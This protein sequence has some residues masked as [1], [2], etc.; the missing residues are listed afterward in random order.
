MEPVV[1]AGEPVIIA[2]AAEPVIIAGEPVIIAD[3][4]RLRSVHSEIS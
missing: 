1:I 3:A 2:D 4:A